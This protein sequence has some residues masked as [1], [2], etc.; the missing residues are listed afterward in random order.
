MANESAAIVQSSGTTAT[1]SGTT[2][3][4]RRLRRA[5]HLP[6]LPQDGRRADRAA[7]SSKPSPS[8]TD[9]GWPSLVAADGDDLEVHYRHTPRELGKEPGM[10]GIIF[11]KAQNKIQDP[12][13]LQRADRDLIDDEDWSGMDIDVKGD[14]Y[15]GLLQ[16]N[17]RTSKSGAGQYFTPRAAHPRHRRGHAPAARADDLRPR[18]RHRRLPARRPRLHRPAHTSSTASQR[19]AP[20]APRPCAAPTSSPASPASAP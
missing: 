7:A 3:S 18:L 20:P 19:E 10:L 9:Y 17:A 15:E 14:I 11:R 6:A 4:V 16:K 12:A 5:A 13:K 2:A 1:S 8:P